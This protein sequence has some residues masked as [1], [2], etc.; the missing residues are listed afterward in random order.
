[1]RISDWSSDVCSSD[2]ETL[3]VEIDALLRRLGVTTVYVTHDQAE[4]MSLPDRI[5]VMDHGKIAQAGTPRE[6]YARPATRFVGDF[7]GTMNRIPGCVPDG[8]F[9][10]T[11]GSVA[12]VSLPTDRKSTRL[13]SSHYCASRLQSSA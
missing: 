3:R 13:N 1:M 11:A 9:V 4:A 8:V 10:C 7:I 2:L 5:I 12:S 6:I